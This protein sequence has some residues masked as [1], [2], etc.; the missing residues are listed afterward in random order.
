MSEVKILH[1]S[2]IHFKRKEKETFREDVQAKMIDAIKKHLG[3]FHTEPDF[4]AVT[5]DIAFS[6]KEYDEAKA[7]FKELKSVLPSKTKFLVVPGNH[8][9]DRRKISKFFSLHHIVQN[10]KTDAFLEDKGEINRNINPKFKAFREFTDTLKPK[11]YR[12]PDD[13]FWVKDF[14]DENVSFLGL[15]SSW[16]CEGDDD[17]NNITLGYPQL[18]SALKKSKIPNKIVLMH[19][20]PINWLNEIDFNLYSNEIF[21]HCQLILHG[22]THADNALVFKNPADS[23][24]CLGA[25]ASYTDD[26]EDGFIGFQFIEIDFRQGE[27]GVKVWP[28][29]LER[30]GMNRFVQDEHRWTGQ[31]GPYFEL[32]T[33]KDDDDTK[34]K[35]TQTKKTTPLPLGIPKQYKDW[36]RQ[37][38]S[39][40]DIDLLAKKGEAITVDLPELYIPI[41]TRNPFYKPKEED[42][43]KIKSDKHLLESMHEP[44]SG[45]DSKGKEPPSIDIEV[46]MG[47]KKYILLRGGAGTGKTTLI[48]HLAYTV[49]HNIGHSSLKGYLPVMVFLK[50]LWPIYREELQ[51]NNKKLIFEELLSIYLGKEKCQLDWE[52]VS[53]Y[54]DHQKALF[55]MDGL[56][57]VPQHLRGYLVDIIAKF[58]FQH[59]QNRFLLTGRPHGITGQAMTRFGNDLHDIEP[60]DDPKIKDFIKKWFRAILG[61]A[62]GLGEVT[63]DGMISDIHQH[64]HISAFTQ[65]PLLLTAVCILYQDGKRIPEQRADLYNRIIDNLIHRRFNDPTQPGKENEIL[66]FLMTLAFEAQKNNRK[67][68]EITDALKILRNI[69]PK[70]QDERQSQYQ[71]RILKL[72]NESEPR[73]GL[74]D[75]VGSDEIQFTHLTFQEFLSAKYMVYEDIDWQPFLDKDWW[76]ETLLLY[77][78]FMSLDRK[79]IGNDIVKNILTTKAN[80]E[81]DEKKRLRLQFLGARAICDFQPVKRDETVV[82][83]AREQMIQLTESDV[84]L[85]DRFQAGELLGSLGDTRFSEDNMVLVPAG[86][87]IRGS[88]KYKNAKPVKRIYLDDFK[89]GV[90]PVTNQEFRRFVD[91]DGYNREE[92]WTKE[93]WQWRIEEKVTEPALLYDREWN[94]PNFPVVGISWYEADTYVKWLS[95]VTKKTYRLPTEAEWEKAARGTEGKIYSWGNTYDKNLCNSRESNLARTSP[96]GIFPKGKS[97]YGCHDMIGNIWEWCTDWYREKYYHSSPNKN[98]TG[99]KTGSRRVF[100][101]GSWLDFAM[102]CACAIRFRD[103]PG[104]RRSF[105]GFRLAR[106]V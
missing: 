103:L 67:T 51:K 27:V 104:F 35:K 96:V 71:Q 95:D 45:K 28:Y 40:M 33:Y 22:H 34:E 32:K 5:G 80:Q 102:D 6:G 39:K 13:Y 73:C 2:D 62:V 12:E 91:Y 63:A 58:Q 78:G 20:P 94:G 97:N 66:E 85:E 101:G 93:G 26:K 98:P 106:S 64:E 19:H 18:M 48:K 76:E 84:A 59:N 54:L 23:C 50:D 44:G 70:K 24:I 47:R 21:H 81:K 25:N 87:F 72:F 17:R 75:C 90:F 77:T 61:R 31:E 56:D 4:A 37:F 11:L 1:L 89:I 30:R 82:S 88:E 65:N 57:E 46:L 92:Y 41:E 36:V 55:L 3:K 53:H 69:F 83:I 10:K 99:P 105:L 86:E 38:H 68:I 42:H 100:R 8:D 79:R 43:K 16:A 15:N 29:R 52:T 60:L 7:F 9:V 49:I 74:F 14:K